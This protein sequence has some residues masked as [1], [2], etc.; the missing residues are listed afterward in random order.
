[1]FS[2]N[3]IST[4][5]GQDLEF[6]IELVD[7]INGSHIVGADVQITVQGQII[8]GNETGS[9]VYSLVQTYQM[10]FSYLKQFPPISR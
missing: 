1:M 2:D 7:K 5:S 3:I 8:Y 6:E 4:V 9:G 10:H